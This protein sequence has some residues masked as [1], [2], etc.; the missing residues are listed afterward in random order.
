MKTKSVDNDNKDSLIKEFETTQDI[1][2]HYDLINMRFGVLIQAS[3]YILI[4][5]GFSTLSTAK[6][7]FLYFFPFIIVLVILLEIIVA[8]WFRRHRNFAQIK[9]K[10]LLEIEKELGWR[11]F[12]MVDEAIKSGK[13][14]TTAIRKLLLIY[15]C[16]FPF[17]LAVAYF[18]IL[19]CPD[20]PICP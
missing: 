15:F 11:Q 9:I 12:T 5:F 18:I 14:K 8:K 17:A 10:R 7:V 19:I 16:I 3:T 2:K 1:I 6:Q 4:Y 13:E 20:K